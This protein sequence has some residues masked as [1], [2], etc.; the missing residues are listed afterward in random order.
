MVVPGVC[1][2][3]AGR[4]VLMMLLLLSGLAP[5]RACP[6]LS[7]ITSGCSCVDERSKAHAAAAPG[8][9][10]SCSKDELSESPESRLLPNRT[11]TL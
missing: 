11:I 8:K 3:P 6:G 5:A 2:P 1:V 7:L 4:L 10:V 9:R